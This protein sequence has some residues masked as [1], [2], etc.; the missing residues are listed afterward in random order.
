MDL[1][2]KRKCAQSLNNGDNSLQPMLNCSELGLLGKRAAPI[3]LFAS[4]HDLSQTL[5]WPS[6]IS[7]LIQPLLT[8]HI[9]TYTFSIGL[10][11]HILTYILPGSHLHRRKGHWT[12]CVSSGWM[13]LSLRYAPLSLVPGGWRRSS[14]GILRMLDVDYSPASPSTTCN[15]GTSGSS[16]R[17][18][19]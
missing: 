15:P 2:D 8:A 7:R 11:P 19:R 5:L 14:G 18:S 6:T 16:S 10:F 13:G 12:E 4:C 3:L 9:H 17:K 1:V